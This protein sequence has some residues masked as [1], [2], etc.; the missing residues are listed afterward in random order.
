MK[1]ENLY[2]KLSLEDM[3]T[4][5]NLSVEFPNTIDEILIELKSKTTWTEL[6]YNVICGLVSFFKLPS[7]SP[8]D[9]NG[10]FNKKTI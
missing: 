8:A 6:S 10:L 1:I 4:L 9:I 3:V 5:V 7:Y 2:E